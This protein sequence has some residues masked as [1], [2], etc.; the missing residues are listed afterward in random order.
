VATMGESDRSTQLARAFAL[1]RASRRGLDTI[2]MR[3]SD[4]TLYEQAMGYLVE[5]GPEIAGPLSNHLK[6]PDPVVRERIAQVLGLVGGQAARTALEG[7]LRDPDVNVARAAE[8][9]L[10]RIRIL[11]QAGA[12]P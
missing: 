4:N 12:R 10:A 11:E 5:L 6:D 9:G 3:V 8:R 1:Q 7:T 2:V